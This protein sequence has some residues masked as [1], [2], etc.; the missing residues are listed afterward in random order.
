M[1]VRS[2]A[3]VK[4]PLSF[5]TKETSVGAS[6][7]SSRVKSHVMLAKPWSLLLSHLHLDSAPRIAGQ[8]IGVAYQMA[9]ACAIGWDIAEPACLSCLLASYC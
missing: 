9:M 2:V 4:A 6:V 8:A 7:G 3:L 5:T 1:M